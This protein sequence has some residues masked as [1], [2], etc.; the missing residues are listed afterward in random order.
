MPTLK[1]AR[2]VSR[3]NKYLYFQKSTICI[4]IYNIFIFVECSTNSDCPD[5][6]ACNDDLDECI[7]ICP[8]C[9][10]NAHCEAKNHIAYCA[11]NLLH[12]GDPYDKGCKKH[13]EYV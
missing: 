6:L 3:I 2:L 12:V 5:H 1:G 8:N 10:A 9:S 4:Y 13:G 7:D 11:C